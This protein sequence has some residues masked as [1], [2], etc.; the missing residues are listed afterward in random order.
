MNEGSRDRHEIV[1]PR[2]DE[3][4]LRRHNMAEWDRK[5]HRLSVLARYVVLHDLT[6]PA[7][8]PPSGTVAPI[9]SITPYSRATI[10]E[11]SDAGFVEIQPGSG[12]GRRDR[13]VMSSGVRDFVVRAHV[14]RRFH[15]LDND[16]PSEFAAYVSHAYPMSRLAEIVSGVLRAA[17]TEVPSQL[18]DPLDRYVIDDRWPARVARSLNEPL[19]NRI[20]AVVQQAKTP[21]PLAQLPERVEGSN[22]YDVR[23][24]VDKLVVRLALVEDIQSATWELVVGIL[25]AVREKISVAGLPRERPPL[26]PCESPK[27]FSPDGGPVVNDM[28]AVLLEVAS[29]PPRLRQDQTL[30]HKEVERF[31]AALDPMARWLLD[32][33]K[34]TEDGRLNR[35]MTWAQALRLARIEPE[36]KQIRLVLTPE[37]HEWLSGGAA[38]ADL[39][40]Y[41]LMSTFEII[42]EL[43]SQHL[44]LFLLGLNPMDTLGP[45]DVHFLGTHVVVLKLD[46][47]KRPPQ[48]F[49]AKPED[50]LALREQLDTTLDRLKMD[51]FYRLDSVESHLAFGEHNPVNRGLPMEQVAVFWVTRSIPAGR[52][53]R[54][55]IGRSVIN[56][57]LLERLV[58]FG[59]FRAA[60]DEEGR[61]CI[62]RGRRYDA[63]FGRE[64]A[65]PDPTSAAIAV[66]RVVVQPDFSVMVIGRNPAPAAE[67]APFCERTTRGGGQGAI[68]LKL[69]RE[70]VVKAVN[71]GL[72][73]AEIAARLERHASKGVPANVLR[74]VR[75]WSTW[76]RRVTASSLIGLRCP[77]SD[78]ADRV[79]AAMKRQAERVDSTLVALNLRKLTTIERNKLQEHGILV[80][81]EPESPVTRSKAR[82][83][84]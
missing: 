71:N 83:K 24:V 42:P 80:D 32:A 35:A 69:T 1:P 54:E 22:P 33:M 48:Y 41:R 21:I 78:T 63:Y 47:A 4:A 13:A 46:G 75:E 8:S 36:G 49:A 65:C 50:H 43:F 37:G 20:L 60:I 79:M 76:V 57:F 9:L 55:D 73:P 66:A 34:W 51:V 58:P 2:L 25:P 59:C 17:G 72:K 84:P 38:E 12:K 30:F 39:E 81:A 82:K 7:N 40:I 26:L 29:Q 3:K 77:D 64:V 11:L 62:A 19:A 28:R 16:R 18:D 74:Q 53:P 67:L 70:S 61:I 52:L 5:W 44:D 14:L 27:A 10:E 23:L 15:L 68:V 56:A 31:Q 45:A 6:R